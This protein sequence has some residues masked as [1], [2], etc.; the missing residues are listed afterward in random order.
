MHYSAKTPLCGVSDIWQ[1]TL[2]KC[3]CGASVAPVHGLLCYSINLTSFAVSTWG[4]E[5]AIK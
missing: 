1:T 4:V 3:S 5:I 2:G